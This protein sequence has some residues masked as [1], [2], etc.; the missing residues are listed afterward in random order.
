M[1]GIGPSDPSPVLVYNVTNTGR[2]PIV[3]THVGG[4]LAKGTHFMVTNRIQLPKA[5]Q[6]GEYFLEYTDVSILRERPQALWAIDSLNKY[7]KIRAKAL[8]RLLNETK[9]D[10]NG[11]AG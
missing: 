7:W 10:A 4:E 9:D 5:L 8:K 2:R 1:G 3:V 6:P 11:S